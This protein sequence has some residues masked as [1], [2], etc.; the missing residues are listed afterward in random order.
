LINNYLLSFLILGVGLHLFQFRTRKVNKVEGS[1]N[2]RVQILVK[3]ILALLI[4]R[5]YVWGVHFTLVFCIS[6]MINCINSIRDSARA[7]NLDLA[8]AITDALIVGLAMFSMIDN[9]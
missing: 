1:S 5:D 4:W 8:V 6:D 9:W 7:S 3:L 2:A